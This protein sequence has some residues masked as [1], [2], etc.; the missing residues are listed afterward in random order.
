MKPT[1][2]LS[3]MINARFWMEHCIEGRGYR[4]GIAVDYDE[5]AVRWQ[6]YERQYQKFEEQVKRFMIIFEDQNK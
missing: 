5:Y 2:Y 3:A 6:K 1:T 4:N